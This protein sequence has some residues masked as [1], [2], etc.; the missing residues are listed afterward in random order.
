MSAVNGPLNGVRILDLTHV[1]A[2]PLA[3]RILS[4]LGAEVVKIERALGRGPRVASIEPIAGWIG[5]QP[6]AEPWNNNAAFVKLARNAQSVSLDLKQKQG[7]DLFLQLVAVADV[8]IENFSAR[9]MP[10]MDLGYEVLRA[11]NPKI[12]YVTMPGYGTSGP[13]KDW[14]AFGPTVEPMTGLG[15]M[16]GYSEDEPRNSAMALMDPIGGTTAVTALLT[17]LRDR[18]QTGKGCYVEL[19]LHE[20]GVSFNGPWLIERQLGGDLRPQGNAHPEMAPHG[21]YRCRSRDLQ[22]DADWIAIACQDQ[23][24]WNGLVS[25]LGADLDAAWDARE[26]AARAEFIEAVIA[27]WTLHLDKDAAAE[28]LQQVGVAAGPVAT[29]PDMLAESQ[30]QARQFFVPYER[31]ATPIPGNPIHMSGLSHDDWSPCPALGA[32]SQ[33]VLQQWLDMSVQQTQQLLKAQIIAERP[34][35]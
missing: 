28:A 35:D 34:P 5:G 8:V 13:Y 17:A 14:V 33:S 27:N 9:A 26:R 31:E 1:W 18:E 4:D 2:G 22:D 20:C 21:M 32:H 11:H 16:L 19:S 30:A 23:Q 7:R 3:T 10:A 6:G 24:A 15:Q 29:A 12:I 25:L